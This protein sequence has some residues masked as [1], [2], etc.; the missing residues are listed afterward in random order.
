MNLLLIFLGEFLGT[1]MLILLGNGVVS[2]ILY[3]RTK[4][5]NAGSL[6]IYIAWGFAVMIGVLIAKSFTLQAG[7]LNPAVTMYS[8]VGGSL[9]ATAFFVYIGS[10]ILGATLGQV[11]VNFAY[12]NFAN[13]PENKEVILD[14]HCNKPVDQ[15]KWFSNIF[16][17]FIG[18][19]VLLS[20]V[21][22][23][24]TKLLSGDAEAAAAPSMVI[25]HALIV[26]FT[27]IVIGASLGGQTGYSINPVRDFM[28]R[29]VYQL[30]PFKNKGS[31][32]WSYSWVPVLAPLMAGAFVGAFSL[33]INNQ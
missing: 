16:S 23:L 8:L 14:C 5:L 24:S 6:I 15:S 20:V 22:I 10:Q 7:H 12:W 3:K 17:E 33:L 9:S 13:A 19:V 18:T 27:I 29:V 32:N 2:N 4:V 1:M 28:P 25:L 31:A 21:A 11:V 26:A 30:T